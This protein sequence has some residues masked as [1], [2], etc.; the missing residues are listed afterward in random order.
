MFVGELPEYVYLRQTMKA[1]NTLILV[2]ASLLLVA[3]E[4]DSTA[5]FWFINDP[6]IDSVFYQANYYDSGQL[7]EEGW[8]LMMS[9]NN[10]YKSFHPSTD[11]DC[12]PSVRV[13]VGKHV[14]Y[15]KNG[16]IETILSY[17]RNTSDTVN[18]I[19]Y[20]KKGA[21]E[22]IDKF[23]E[24]PIIQIECSEGESQSE[25][26]FKYYHFENYSKGALKSEGCY[27]GN[28]LKIGCWKYYKKNG[29][30]KKQKYFENDQM[31]RK[32]CD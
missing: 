17:P 1:L 6:D 10:T 3:Q 9:R 26:Y 32:Y 28:Y 13:F 23:I 4:I 15:Y 24:R 21:V 25:K 29:E 20:D 22:A 19:F 30:L 5:Y 18:M 31:I 8:V 2:V 12:I 14:F 7:Y 27:F 11:F 16:S